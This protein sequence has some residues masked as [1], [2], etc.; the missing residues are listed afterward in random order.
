MRAK[1][2]I[3]QNALGGK[4]GGPSALARPEFIFVNWREMGDRLS[5]YPVPLL[6]KKWIMLMQGRRGAWLYRLRAF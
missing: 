2:K 6:T 5:S 3:M 4:K 1:T